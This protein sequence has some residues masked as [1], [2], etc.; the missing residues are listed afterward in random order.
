MT[1]D[2]LSE[3]I[4]PSLILHFCNNALSVVWIF[5]SD[6]LKYAVIISV[7]LAVLSFISVIFIIMERKRHISRIKTL[8]ASGDS[9]KLGYTPLAV[10]VPTVFFAISEL[11]S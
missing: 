11:I 1:L 3:S 6:T 8:L 4:F 9:Y 7:S 5:L 2:L 10:I